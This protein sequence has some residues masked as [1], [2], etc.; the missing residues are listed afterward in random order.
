LASSLHGDVILGDEAQKRRLTSFRRLNAMVRNLIDQKYSA[1]L[2]DF[3][4]DGFPDGVDEPYHIAL[5]VALAHSFLG[6]DERA[7]YYLAQAKSFREGTAGVWEQD[8]AFDIFAGEVVALCAAGRWTQAKRLTKLN[9]H[10]HARSPMLYRALLLL[11]DGPPF[12][13]VADAFKPCFGAPYVGLIAILA[14]RV[15]AKMSNGRVI[16]SLSVAEMDVLRMIELGRSNKDI[17]ATRSRSAETVKRQVASLFRKL[18]VENRTSAVAIAR[19]R[20]LL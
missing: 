9:V 7:V 16:Q 19:E 3:E 12:A 6:D 13:G 4:S 5:S 11:C 10:R 20:G 17:A 8:G 15:I 2:A 1:V 14:H 18:G